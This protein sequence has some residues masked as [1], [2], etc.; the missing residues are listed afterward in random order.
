MC[1]HA[2]NGIDDRVRLPDTFGRLIPTVYKAKSS[3]FLSLFKIQHAGPRHLVCFAWLLTFSTRFYYNMPFIKRLDDASVFS[4]LFFLL[5]CILS[6][7]H[8][9]FID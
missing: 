6:L 7:G 3:H 4:T 1:M 2:W 9:L 8:S 5:P